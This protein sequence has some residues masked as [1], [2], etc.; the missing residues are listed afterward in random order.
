LTPGKPPRAPTSLS[1]VGIGRPQHYESDAVA[2]AYHKRYESGFARWK[3]ARKL[4][5]L[6][7]WIAAPKPARVLEVACGPG[8]FY[9]THSGVWSV[10]LDRA[11]PMLSRFRAQHA[12]A[13]L[14]RGDAAT[15][16]FD[17]GTFDVVLAIRFL[18]HLRGAYRA[19]VLGELVRVT[20]G[21]VILDGR[22]RYNLRFASRWI[23]RRLGLA[24]A[25]KLRHTYG[26]FRRELETAGLEVEEFRSIGWGLS[27][28]F[29]VRA[30]KR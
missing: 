12:D 7:R 24:H 8:R 22:H 13:R 2:A 19:R 18:A 1:E 15:R 6:R 3:H 17:D 23:R 10:S 25:D 14:V 28:R 27:A 9:A 16:P 29:L 5:L 11:A 4:R 30:R 20:R 26:E 21:S